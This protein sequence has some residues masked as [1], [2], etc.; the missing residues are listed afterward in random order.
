MK[1][2]LTIAE[3]FTLLDASY[4]PGKKGE[5]ARVGELRRYKHALMQRY[6]F[7]E[8]T[9]SKLKEALKKGKYSIIGGDAARGNTHFCGRKKGNTPGITKGNFS[10]FIYK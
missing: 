1:I 10:A 4:A 6:G 5:T 7:D 3:L 8:S 9:I 2:R